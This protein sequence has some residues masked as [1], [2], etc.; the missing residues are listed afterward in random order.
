MSLT[1]SICCGVWD[2]CSSGQGDV[3]EVGDAGSGDG[4]GAGRAS[5]VPQDLPDLHPRQRMLNLGTNPTVRAVEVL[6]P[7]RQD[8]TLV[9]FA[10]R[11]DHFRVAAVSAVSDHRPAREF[12][13][14]D[15]RVVAVAGLRVT[16]GDH[17]TGAGI[18]ADL[19]VGGVAVVLRWCGQTMVAGGDQGAVDDG[20][21]V[22]R[23]GVGP[24]SV[25]V[26]ARERR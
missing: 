14:V 5:V 1:P 18:D 20:D 24:G 10:V 21:L 13:V 26:A 6:F 22:A 19:Q 25:P 16:Q 8:T 23:V 11:D 9:G 7:L 4:Q 3:V 12:L 17:Q 15:D 2:L